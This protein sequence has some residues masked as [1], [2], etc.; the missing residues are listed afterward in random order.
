MQIFITNNA[1]ILIIISHTNET[2]TD[3]RS[4]KLRIFDVIRRQTLNAS[5]FSR[6]SLHLT[7]HISCVSLTS[8]QKYVQT[9]L[10]SFGK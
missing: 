9:V 7:L 2:L 3:T 4:T 5:N 1:Q 8:H 6:R 10:I